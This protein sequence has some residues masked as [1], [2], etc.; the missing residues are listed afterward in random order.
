MRAPVL[1]VQDGSLTETK[2]TNPK[3]LPRQ[4]AMQLGWRVRLTL[5]GLFLEI[6]WSALWP[7]TGFIG[8]WL[9][10][11]FL[12]VWLFVPGVVHLVCF[13]AAFGASGLSLYRKLRHKV[14]PSR[15]DALR[16]MELDSDLFHRPRKS[17]V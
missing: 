8:I 12:D 7:A 1:R 13:I 4:L 3:D 14:W 11:S 10:L 17:V 16:R 2:D 6:I 9:T 5:A 15:A